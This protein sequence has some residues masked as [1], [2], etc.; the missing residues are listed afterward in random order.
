M[1]NSKLPLS[2]KS[3]LW[4]Y[5]LSQIDITKHQKLIISQ[6]LNFGTKDATD[7]LFKTYQLKDIRQ[8]AQS[9]P[10]DQWDKKSLA[11]WSSYLN[12]KPITRSQ[13]ILHG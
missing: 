11:L 8:A 13:K 1:I 4:S 5:D 2:V 7:W 10:L 12:I 3:V 9:I 6:I